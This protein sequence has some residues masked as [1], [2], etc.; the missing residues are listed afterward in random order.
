MPYKTFLNDTDKRVEGVL[1]KDATDANW[2]DNSKHFGD[3]IIQNS[4]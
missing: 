3:R 2:R 1:I 4:L